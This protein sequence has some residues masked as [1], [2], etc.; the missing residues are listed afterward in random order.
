MSD[1]LLIDLDTKLAVFA[2]KLRDDLQIA[3]P[4]ANTL[5][6]TIRSDIASLNVGS[7]PNLAANNPLSL[8]DRY[9]ELQQFLLW[10]EQ[11]QTIRIFMVDCLH[12]TICASFI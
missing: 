9:G 12:S 11:A 6:S 3:A 2:T 10:L 1:A 8:K 4:A 5:A 7:L